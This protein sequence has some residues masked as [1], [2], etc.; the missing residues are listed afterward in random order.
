MDLKALNG[1]GFGWLE[2]FEYN[3][4]RSLMIEYE[5]EEERRLGIEQVLQTMDR[6]IYYTSI[7]EE[8]LQELDL[9]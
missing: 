9:L 7:K 1:F 8:L 4:K 6:I 2:W 5:N 3:I